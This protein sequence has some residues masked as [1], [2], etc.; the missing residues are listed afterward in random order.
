MHYSEHWF[1]KNCIIT[2][3]ENHEFATKNYKT[4]FD[5]FYLKRRRCFKFTCL[6]F[7]THFQYLLKMYA[8]KILK[9]HPTKFILYFHKNLSKKPMCGFNFSI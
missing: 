3:N 1:K 4:S 2:P 7:K 6:T 9:S 8:M 5:K